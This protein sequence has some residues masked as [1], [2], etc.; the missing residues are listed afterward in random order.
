MTETLPLSFPKEAASR[1]GRA[2][3]LLRRAGVYLGVWTLVAVYMICAEILMM[4]DSLQ[5][6]SLIRFAG[7]ALVRNYGWAMVSLLTLG[8]VRAF[9]L[10]HQASPR[11]WLIHLSASVGITLLGICI[12]AAEMPLFYTPRYAYLPRVWVLTKQYFHFCFLIYY[13]GVVGCHEGIQLFRRLRER[14]QTALLLQSR[15]AQ[16]QLQALEMHLSPHFL[17]NTLNAVA[18]LIH[19]DPESADLILIKLSQLLRTSLNRSNEQVATLN[20]ELAFLE[21]YL[22]I[23]RLRFGPRLTVDIQVSPTLQ[24]ALVPTFMLQPLVEQAIRQGVTPHASGGRVGLRARTEGFSLLL[25]IEDDARNSQASPADV[26]VFHNVRSRLQQ[27]YGDT[28]QLELLAGPG[29]GGLVRISL[30]YSPAQSTW[31]RSGGLP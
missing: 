24:E 8:L 6:D 20:D 7:L 17:F 30:P 19:S 5:V 16:A 1:A 9:P 2:M 10:H 12:M 29:G 13:W 22:D 27:L 28:Q 4:R 15:L 11:T 23:E 18:A 26:K 25:E 14:Q 21:T 3:P 31:I